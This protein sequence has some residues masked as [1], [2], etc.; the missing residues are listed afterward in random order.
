MLAVGDSSPGIASAMRP[1]RCAIARSTSCATTTA[2]TTVAMAVM[3][4][5]LS[6]QNEAATMG[7]EAIARPRLRALGEALGEAR[8]AALRDAVL[9]LVAS[10][11]LV[12]VVAVVAA[13][14]AP[15][16]DGASALAFDRP[17]LTHPF[18]PALDALFAPLARWDSVW[19]L[20]VARSGYGGDDG[21]DVSIAEIDKDGVRLVAGTWARTADE[22]GP[23]AAGL[24]A[25]CL[26]R[27][28]SAGLS[29]AP[30]E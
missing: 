22:R 12:W 28:T 11:M 7:R 3:A 10:R 21:V 24:R 4:L 2:I 20:D 16:A 9:A 8:A 1:P 18:G 5:R 17:D 19:Y 25:S 13:A 23:I 6:V 14:V 29:S 26:E 30:A 15:P 27:L